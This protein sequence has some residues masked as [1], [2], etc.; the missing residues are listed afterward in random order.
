MNEK[1]DVR[2]LGSLELRKTPD[3]VVEAA[4]QALIGKKRRKRFLRTPEGDADRLFLL[5]ALF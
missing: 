3:D 4:A 1:R 5:E 2:R